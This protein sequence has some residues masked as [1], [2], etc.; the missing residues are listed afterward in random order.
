MTVFRFISLFL[1]MALTGCDKASVP[2]DTAPNLSLMVSAPSVAD[3]GDT[4]NLSAILSANGANVNSGVT[5]VWEDKSV[6]QLGL[7]SNNDTAS[8]VALAGIDEAIILVTATFDGS[9]VSET[10][11]I[12]I[13]QP[14][15]LTITTPSAVDVGTSVDLS[16]VLSIDGVDVNSGVT[17][18]WE[19]KSTQQ[20]GLTSSSDTANF[21]AI[22]GIHEAVILVTA[23]FDGVTVSKT[24]S[25]TI[26]PPP[27]LSLTLTAPLSVNVGDNVNISAMV[28][29]DGIDV[30]SGV[31]YVWEDK[32]TQQ[33]GLASGDDTGSFV[34][35]GS[36][37]EAVILVTA[38]FEGATVSRTVSITINPPQAL[39][40]AL[41]IT[42][43]LNAK[44]GDSVNLSAA[45]SIDGKDVITGVTY[46]WEDKSLQPI[47]LTS[48]NS[49][50]NFV[51]ITGISEA[52]I[53]VKATFDG[54]TVSKT[55]SI[56]INPAKPPPV[57]DLAVSAPI[58]A[59]VDDIVNLSAVFSID[60]VDV[61][62]GVTYVW[63]DK[64]I[65]PLALTSN[66]N[67]ASFVALAGIDEA[68][69]QVTVSFG[70]V[71][72]SKT[73]SITI[74]PSAPSLTLAVT[75]PTSVDVGVSVDL[76][77]L[78]S[79]NGGDVNSG[80]TYVWEDK[81]AQ[82]VFLSSSNNTA[83]FI[84]IIGTP[85]A[86]ISV[87][88]SFGGSTVSKTV[89]IA[90]NPPHILDIVFTA[91]ASADVGDNVN[92]RALLNIDGVDVTSGV[93]YLWEDKSTQPVGLTSNSDTA[94]FIAIAG[95]PEA[96]ISVTASF[97]SS[98]VSK[99]V[100][101]T[102]NPPPT[103]IITVT[104]PLAV[105]IGDSVALGAM[106]SANGVDVNSGVTYTW[107]DK[108]TQPVGLT[109]NSD[110]AS[111]IAIAGIHE[112]V[113]LVT[114][115]FKGATVSKT[116]SIIINP[117]PNLTLTV[118]AP[119]PVDAGT[120]VDLVAMVSA[121]GTDVN[122]GITYVW[123]D[124]ST[125]P[126]VL[127]SKDNTANFVAISGVHEV[128]ILVTAKFKGAVVSKTIS[129]TINPPPHL[130]LTLTAP[131]IVD[132]GDSVDLIAMVSINGTD[133]TTGV[134]YA[135]EDKSA[136]SIG[137]ASKDNTAHFVAVAGIDEPI[138]LITASYKGATVSE[139]VSIAVLS[140]VQPVEIGAL[141]ISGPTK[142]KSSHQV[143]LNALYTE[144]S[145]VKPN[146]TITWAQD[147]GPDAGFTA[148]NGELSFTAPDV[149]QD[150][151][152]AFSAQTTNDAGE[153]FDALWFVTV[154]PP[155][156]AF[157]NQLNTVKQ[158]TSGD[159]VHLTTQVSQTGGGGS[160][161]Y[162]W[163]QL[164]GTPVAI[165]HPD[166]S[167]PTATFIAPSAAGKLTFSVTATE[168][169]SGKSI[170]KTQVVN[171]LG[172]PFT[173]QQ[174]A[175]HSVFSGHGQIELKGRV[176]GGT[177][178]FS[179][180]W[181]QTAGPQA[182][183]SSTSAEN[184]SVTPPI[185]TTDTDITWVVTVTDA[186]NQSVTSTHVVTVKAAPKLA[187]SILHPATE[188]VAEGDTVLPQAHISGG[189]GNYSI[190]WTSSVVTLVDETT[191]APSFVVP[192][193]S[194]DTNIVV[195][196]AV[197]DGVNQI[198]RSVRYTAKPLFTVSSHQNQSGSNLAT[199]PNQSTHQNNQIESGKTFKPSVDVHENAASGGTFTYVWT[200]VKPNPAPADLVIAGANTAQPIVSAPSVTSITPV[201]LQAVITYSV[202]GKSISKTVNSQYQV[203]PYNSPSKPTLTLSMAGH[204]S[205]IGGR[206]ANPTVSVMNAAGTIT[207]KWTQIS[208]P[209]IVGG[210]IGETTG[211][212]YFT[213]PTITGGHQNLV[214]EVEVGDGTEVKTAQVTF[215]ISPLNIPPKLPLTVVASNDETVIA[216]AV[217]T[218][219]ATVT[220]SNGTPTYAWTQTSGTAVIIT[221]ENTATPS[222]MA[223][224]TSGS[225]VLEVT[226][227]DNDNA[228]ITDTVSYQVQTAIKLTAGTS[229]RSVSEGNTVDLLA[230]TTDVNGTASYAW[231]V[232]SDGGTGVVTG[233]I[234]NPALAHTSLD[235]PA[236]DQDRTLVLQVIATDNA[237]SATAKATVTI[238]IR[239]LKMRVDLGAGSNIP[240]GQTGYLQANVTSGKGPFSYA[241]ADSTPPSL[242]ATNT[243]NPSFT[244]PNV[245][246]SVD[247]QFGVTVTDS[248]NNT[249]SGSIIMTVEQPPFSV[250][251]GVDF[252][253]TEGSTVQLR[254]QGVNGAGATWQ[255]KQTAGQN[256]S[257]SDAT[258][259]NPTFIA[260]SQAEGVKETFSFTVTG[261]SNGQV[262]SASVNVV[263][264]GA[265]DIDAH[266]N[267]VSVHAG[268]TVN[269]AGSVTGA[270]TVEK[271]AWTQSSAGLSVG[272]ITNASAIGDVKYLNASFVAPAVNADTTLTFDF[273][274]TGAGNVVHVPVTV[275]IVANPLTVSA[276]G[277]IR[278]RSGATVQLHAVSSNAANYAW[279]QTV[280]T[281]TVTL[282]N[283][284][285]NGASFVAPDVTADTT[286]T[287]EV[288]VTGGGIPGTDTV[289]VT[290][291]EPTIVV[292]TNSAHRINLIADDSEPPTFIDTTFADS[293]NGSDVTP[294][295][296]TWTITPNPTPP[297]TLDMVF[298]GLN[299][300][301]L[302]INPIGASKGTYT[303]T[304][305]AGD[306]A[307]HYQSGSKSFVIDI[308]PA[309]PP[310][311]KTVDLSANTG[312][313][314]AGIAGNH[315]LHVPIISGG[316]PP[317]HYN[318]GLGADANGLVITGGNTDNPTVAF[319][320]VP[321]T[322][323]AISGKISLTITDANGDTA[324]GNVAYSSTPALNPIKPVSCHLCR[325]PKFICERSHVSTVCDVS[326][327][328]HKS[329]T[330]NS[331]L[332]YCINDIENLQDGS[333]YVSRRCA[334]AEEVNHDW[335]TGKATGFTEANTNSGTDI[336]HLG[337][338]D[339]LAHK[340]NVV[341]LK[342]RHFS[343]SAACKGDNCN[344]ETVPDDLLGVTNGVPN[345]VTGVPPT[346]KVG[347]CP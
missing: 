56:T 329:G 266:S 52:V 276:G 181:A 334:T 338:L 33:I 22:S 335:F 296:T 134:T 44:V 130:D 231:S 142:V 4:V 315:S 325:G 292:N 236:V 283:G 103:L 137:L 187:V 123:E 116:I 47:G 51:A 261:T 136:Q 64:S 36:I 215:D 10:I 258:L 304:M 192:T 336:G 40:S 165:A 84:A 257:L 179:Y 347:V 160:F 29:A 237:N 290:V 96:V 146:A 208:G 32:S 35:I 297:A 307:N 59:N 43:P 264:Q 11:N 169:G 209:N 39:N 328:S 298:S 332:Q 205:V 68:I 226:V 167:Q 293:V 196:L 198:T 117:I 235:I 252:S 114:A 109:S 57:L 76:S 203:V 111:F 31:T 132:V 18:M 206:L 247:L 193:V 291:F 243:N 127:S 345:S 92:L 158:A 189:T 12:V 175:Q 185:V 194:K 207:Y 282:I 312:L 15:K 284:N 42:A 218:P 279:S 230:S 280:G 94:S 108:S 62:N 233:D 346:P 253:V 301:T 321:S 295:T 238:N 16:A 122:T 77:A 53:L 149:N 259:A 337:R 341:I 339:P 221:D 148:N 166:I 191:A 63:E 309:T 119:S 25:I 327:S 246:H 144:T 6:Q 270:G 240:S 288:D 120:S 241:W 299:T 308:K 190:R 106:I 97:G 125:Q 225:I 223:P 330:V 147:K 38:Y 115:E 342:D 104:A 129:I 212:P 222:F 306:S 145:V 311:P 140:S 310:M 186:N 55:V 74:N 95:I 340:Y 294:A 87:T 54:A 323:N 153:I 316:L 260:P 219:R 107:E 277:D 184:P 232:V 216:N 30:N 250:N 70:S 72:V 172:K 174:G 272:T 83:N 60:G 278:V 99:T 73:V 228:P 289:N 180:S 100:S 281:P 21:V 286:L 48:T 267:N 20:V 200:V 2:S 3:A 105:D 81:S 248:L 204:E 58:D 27:N 275:T 305:T 162:V 224:T 220:N 171:V 9:S 102:V 91:P 155:D 75:A 245:T 217:V 66:S 67:T 78:V 85:E 242:S 255:W 37:H 214:L 285:T 152:F 128:V 249:A 274:A 317:Y 150:T 49:T 324:T 302:E 159:T 268:A 13:N 69:I 300:A 244:A 213:M 273:T 303:A 24:T 26:N 82:P 154:P 199:G 110:T 202:N 183:I 34:A 161:T 178:P 135:W 86:V 1:L 322:C 201:E 170:S 41:T 61:S 210:I 143:I 269:L 227:T 98:T 79:V 139:K 93:T 343:F 164:T 239:D 23:S 271:L 229:I 176:N 318:W 197:S 88:A 173:P 195:N 8:F 256:V 156:I 262:K 326:Q 50:A 65:Q 331:D 101:I 141:T 138:V 151:E 28:S 168:S 313:T 254:A 157:T 121:N 17:Y 177:A 320:A 182:I 131:S 133:V 234:A 314:V 211:N 46:E 344:L 80:V 251:A 14:P 89:S 113:I 163:Q 263:V 112:A 7:T 333:R 188:D 45:F 126:V 319:P 19:D 287:F 124:K 71:M 265:P 90:I 118:T 5:Y